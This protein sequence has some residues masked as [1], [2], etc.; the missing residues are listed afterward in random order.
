MEE[1]EISGRKKI[2]YRYDA[3]RQEIEV[4]V[5]EC[6][7]RFSQNFFSYQF[8]FKSVPMDRRR[9][10]GKSPSDFT[11]RRTRT[12]QSEWHKSHK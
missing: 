12:V 1:N 9:I 8:E 7:G 2:R 5:K 11:E 6:H 10:S 4:I 3:T